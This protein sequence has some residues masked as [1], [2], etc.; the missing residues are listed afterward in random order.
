MKKSDQ[1]NWKDPM[2]WVVAIFLALAVF[3]MLGFCLWAAVLPW[4]WLMS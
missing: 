2:D 1:F 3:F 4:R